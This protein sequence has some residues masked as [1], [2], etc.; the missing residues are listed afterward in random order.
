MLGLALPLGERMPAA[1]N[2]ASEARPPSILFYT[3][4]QSSPHRAPLGS[5]A[6]YRPQ[7]MRC[8]TSMHTSVLSHLARCWHTA[9]F[10]LRPLHPGL[11]FSVLFGAGPFRVHFLCCL[12]RPLLWFFFVVFL[13]RRARFCS[14][15]SSVSSVASSS[16][17]LAVYQSRVVVNERNVSS[18]EQSWNLS[19][20][21]Y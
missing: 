18:M 14:R 4:D 16:T 12:F 20:R 19:A 13:F 1:S 11:R 15:C 7:L 10:W 3:H 21:V 6:L 2:P 8:V 5:F 17:Q 9:C